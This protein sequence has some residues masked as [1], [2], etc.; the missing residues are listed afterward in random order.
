MTKPFADRISLAALTVAYEVEQMA[1]AALAIDAAS[2]VPIHHALL[3]ST[4]L[5]GR[6]LIEFLLNSKE[7]RDIRPRDLCPGWH[8]PD[9]DE[10]TTR[11]R[12]VD[13]KD[14]TDK[15]LAHLSWERV[16]D[17][18]SQDAPSWPYPLIVEEIVG[19]IREFHERFAEC[20]PLAASPLGTCLARI[21]RK[22]AARRVDTKTFYESGLDTTTSAPTQLTVSRINPH[23]LALTDFLPER[24]PADS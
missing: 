13:L 24:P 7:K 10:G 1:D 16:P 4:L 14:A 5:H 9:D 20:N 8:L 15:H 22:V 12:L 18:P 21:E 23:P 3:E 6:A 2:T 11:K 17:D 19:H